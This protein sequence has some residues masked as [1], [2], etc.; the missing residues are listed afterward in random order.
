MELKRKS[1]MGDLFPIGLGAMP[2]SLSGRPSQQD[3]VRVISAFIEHGGNFIDTAD[4]YALDMT[5]AGHNER[6]VHA[7]VKACGLQHQVVVAT[8]G[9]GT[10]PDGGWSFRGGG[11]PRHLREACEA[12][13]KRF[14]RD[15]HTLY[16]LHG[17]DPEVPLEDS[18]GELARLQEEGKIQ[19][20][21]IA[22]VTLAQ[23]EM[24]HQ[25]APLAAIQNRCN[26]FCKADL[27]NGLLDFCTENKIIYVPYCPMGGWGE[28]VKLAGSSLFAPLIEQYD[29]SY[30][31][32]CLSWLLQKQ[33]S[34]IP[35]PGVH[36]MSQVVSNLGAASVY[37]DEGAIKVIDEIIDCYQPMHID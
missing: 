14:E 28:H 4:I 9:G 24:A 18:W 5:E 25:M 1:A 27:N 32:I 23:A 19:H 21:G 35:I 10:R 37:L 22:N 3:A 31:T 29:A 13:L 36:S 15:A 20:L 16:Y 6:L 7:A 26:P 34:I 30:Y 2:L 8:K 33:H 17:P 11:S 12:S